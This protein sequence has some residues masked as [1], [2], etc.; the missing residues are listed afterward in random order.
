MSIAILSNSTTLTKEIYEDAD[1]ILSTTEVLMPE[2][3]GEYGLSKLSEAKQKLLDYIK[4]SK[5]PITYTELS[6]LAAKDMRDADFSAILQ[7]FVNEKK[8]FTWVG[9]NNVRFYST[10]KSSMNLQ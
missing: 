10:A 7:G 1:E 3:L 6:R 5:A 4:Q 9:A 8:V 2:A